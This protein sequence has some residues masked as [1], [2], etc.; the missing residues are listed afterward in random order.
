MSVEFVLIYRPH[1]VYRT[2]KFLHTLIE[3]T[4]YLHVYNPVLMDE[5]RKEGDNTSRCG[6]LPTLPGLYLS[7]F[8]PSQRGFF[9]V[10]R[11][12]WR[13]RESMS[14]NFQTFQDP[15]HQF[16]GIGRLVSETLYLLATLALLHMQAKLIPWKFLHSL[17]VKKFGIWRTTHVCLVRHTFTDF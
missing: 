16:H 6:G 7:T 15:R 13:E 5:G 8:Q 1:P 3:Y 4:W 10:H 2:V 17:K 11:F 9:R 12:V 14:P